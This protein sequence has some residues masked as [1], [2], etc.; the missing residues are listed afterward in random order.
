RRTLLAMGVCY[1]GLAIAFFHDI[2]VAGAGSQV[3]LGAAWVFASAVTYALYFVGTGVMVKRIGSMRLAGL[4]GAASSLMVLGHFGLTGD[5]GQ[6]ANL[7][8]EIWLYAA[9]MAV[10]STVLPV[11]WMAL[12][13]QRMGAAHTAAIGNLGP[14]MTVFAAWL[15][16][17]ETISVYQL[18]GLAMVM[19]GISR[20]RP[21]A[22]QPQPKAQAAS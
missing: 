9:L 19:F 1:L 15:L 22:P 17:S 14:V 18:V 20:L 16:L 12:A 6:L 8:G 3:L 11:Y 13:V 2:G 10:C 21:S 5:I 7:S 4:A